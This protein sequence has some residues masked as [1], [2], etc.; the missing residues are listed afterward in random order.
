MLSTGLERAD[1]IYGY[2]PDDFKGS[3]GI[4]LYNSVRTMRG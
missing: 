1:V 2:N 4:S 3:C